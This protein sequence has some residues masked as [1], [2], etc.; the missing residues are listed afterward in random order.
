VR[1]AKTARP[2]AHG[3][4]TPAEI[5][6]QLIAFD[7]DEPLPDLACEYCGAEVEPANGRVPLYCSERHRRDASVARAADRSRRRNP[8]PSPPR[9]RLMSS[10]PSHCMML[11]AD[12]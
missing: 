9:R 3:E 4:D 1:N 11:R 12:G 2:R 10:W 8:P 6:L 7:R 5:A